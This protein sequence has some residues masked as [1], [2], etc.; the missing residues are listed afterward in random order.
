MSGLTD[1]K[2]VWTSKARTAPSPDAV[3][4]RS[5]Y[6]P[7]H[8]TLLAEDARKG[9]A[10]EPW[11]SL[12]DIGC[13]TGRLGAM[14][15]PLVHRYVGLDFVPEMLRGQQGVAVADCRELPLK[16]RSFGKLLLSGVVG[17]LDPQGILCAFSELRRV[18][19]PGG[20][21]FVS[22]CYDADKSDTYDGPTTWL[23]PDAW[24]HVGRI[25]GW[26]PR[27]V[28]CNPDLFEASATFNLVLTS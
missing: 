14:L 1:W 20:R 23:T 27:I 17:S 5:R 12:L 10:L 25:S 7:E 13:G 16:A 9:L 22:G 6:T 21:A 24:L 3:V 2:E 4:G 8:W 15:K 28:P 19:K 18:A 11:D 26:T